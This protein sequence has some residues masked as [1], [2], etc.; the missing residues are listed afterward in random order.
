MLRT[1]SRQLLRVAKIHTTRAALNA[2]VFSM[3]AMSPTMEEGG[4]VEWK[5]KEGDSFS[6]G[7]TLLDVETDKATISVDAI[8]DGIMAKIILQNGTKEIKVGTP[9]AVTAEPEDDLSN[10]EMPSFEE[11]SAPA[12][13]AAVAAEFAPEPVVKESHG[14][15]VSTASST[16]KANISQTFFPSV[17]ILLHANGISRDEAI[18]KISATGPNGKILK[19]DVLAYLGQISAEHNV[20]IASYIESN[21]H[22]DLSNIELRENAPQ[23]FASGAESTKDSKKPAKKEPVVVSKEFIIS[24]EVNLE[25]LLHEAEMA[26]YKPKIVKSDYFDP[27]FEDLITPSRRVDRFTVSSKVEEGILNIKLTLNDKCYDAKDKAEIYIS[28]LEQKLI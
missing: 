20:K 9:I 28:V 15:H 27:L 5:V 7:D 21:T 12:K 1:S 22:L 13:E 2:K 11:T 17:E 23:S 14:A 18:G 10:L 26:A 3:P 16:T 24:E 4:I 6:S 19:G 25:S 8:D